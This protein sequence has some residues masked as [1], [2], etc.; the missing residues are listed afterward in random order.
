M[1]KIR[2]INKEIRLPISYQQITGKLTET[3]NMGL[4]LTIQQI[5]IRMQGKGK[6]L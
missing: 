4:S 3:L 2:I 6:V 1:R 5:G